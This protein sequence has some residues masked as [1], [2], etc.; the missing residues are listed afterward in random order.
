MTTSV[1]RL[2]GDFVDSIHQ[3]ST[4][5]A[6]GIRVEPLKPPQNIQ[7]YSKTVHSR[8]QMAAKE[9][10]NPLSSNSKAK[11]LSVTVLEDVQAVRCAEF[12]PSGRVYAIGSNS[13]TLRVCA[14]PDL[15][16]LTEN[17]VPYQPTVLFKRTK[18]HKVSRAK[19]IIINIY[20]KMSFI[21][22]G[23]YLLYGMVSRW[24]SIGHWK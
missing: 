15:G 22:S 8:D 21:I 23:I 9:N 18:H 19:I 4:S 16:D 3:Q 6:Q 20:F 12:H 5:G 7:Q 2:F 14:Y 11:F 10:S 1:D 13:K 17:H 24:K